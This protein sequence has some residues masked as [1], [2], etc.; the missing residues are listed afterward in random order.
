MIALS[1]VVP[2]L[3][4]AHIRMLVSEEPAVLIEGPR[5]SGKSTVLHAIAGEHGVPVVDLDDLPTR[6]AIL[7]GSVAPLLSPG[8][9]V[10]DE[11]QHAPGVLSTVKR[12]VD[13][14]GGPGRFLLAGSVS[15]RLLPTGT[16]TLTGRVHRVSLMPLATGEL[17]G[18]Q[19]E[20][21]VEVLAAD[22][23]PSVRSEVD[24]DGVFELVA[25]GG[26][27]AALFRP[28]PKLRDRW[29][30]SYLST[31]ADRDLPSLVDIRN[32]GAISRLYRL[33]A[34]RTASIVT[35]TE[36]AQRLD[37]KPQTARS[38]LDLLDRFYLTHEL[39]SWTVGVSARVGRKPKL[40]VT[41]TGLA[42]AV[43]GL[44]AARLGRTTMGGLFLESFVV[45]ELMKQAAMIDQPLAL[46]HFRDRT[47]AEVDLV[48]ERSDGSVIAVEVKSAATVNRSDGKGLRF[49]R[50]RLGDRL[51]AGVVFHTGPL[52]V[53]L[54]D[55]I[56]ATP[57]SALWGGA[58]P[59]SEQGRP[60]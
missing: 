5:G 40:H 48:V 20:W 19:P 32:P 47:G 33:S 13:R 54:D 3:A 23:P 46:S 59:N 14:E 44:D 26:Y 43:L 41:D 53:Q 24:R 51:I 35:M 15:G 10:I 25:A 27:P 8:L 29:F 55:R 4:D 12:V 57:V 56:W 60:S 50:D 38:Y 39:P 31:V 9:V 18:A 58:G 7:E 37:V 52:T 2:R 1:Q 30:A 28:T 11:F 36:L 16:E 6:A 34:E 42:A 21:L 22:E 49:L 17:L 45:T